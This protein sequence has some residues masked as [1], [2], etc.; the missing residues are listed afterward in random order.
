METQKQFFDS[1][2]SDKNFHPEEERHRWNDVTYTDVLKL[3]VCCFCGG[4][5]VVVGGIGD[6]VGV[7]G[8]CSYYSGF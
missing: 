5:V 7:G 2:A 1:I 6:G 3:E 4:V 8:Y